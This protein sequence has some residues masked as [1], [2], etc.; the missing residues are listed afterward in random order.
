MSKNSLYYIFSIFL[1]FSCSLEEGEGGKATISGNIVFQE[2]YSNPLLGIKDSVINE[3]PAVD[4]KVFIT[5]GDNSIYDDDFNTDEFG[6]Y[7][8]TNLTKGDYTL[9]VYSYCDTCDTEVTAIYKDITLSSHKENK[10]V[11]TIYIEDK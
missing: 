1:F 6:N 9:T 8:F 4:E 7:K 5:Y 11:E 3:Y 2:I 10:T